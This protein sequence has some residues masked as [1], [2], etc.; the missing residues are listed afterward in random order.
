MNVT[1]LIKSRRS[2]RQYKSDTL[3]PFQIN[4]ILD[5]GRWAPSGLNNQPWRFVVITS[6][7][8]RA[9][10]AGFTHYGKTILSAPVTIAVFLD[11]NAAYNRDK[12]LMAM[13]A[14]IQNM[15][16]AAHAR[17]LG[18]C[19]LG[20][21]LN[22]KDEVREFLGLGAHLEL[23]ALLTVG[24]ARRAKR[25]GKRKDMKTLILART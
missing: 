2:V 6:A 5:A 7:D 4:A 1:H 14:C 3:S 9:G 16:L 11:M 12:D 13:G 20:E 23:A 17:G 19:W 10:L 8:K 15:L 22:R 18:T 21:I 25:T 24:S